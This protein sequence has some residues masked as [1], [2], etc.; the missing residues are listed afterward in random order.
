MEVGNDYCN[1]YAHTKVSLTIENDQNGQWHQPIP[2]STTLVSSLQD[3]A[4]PDRIP[5]NAT[6]ASTHRRD[7]PIVGHGRS[8]A[9]GARGDGGGKRA[10]AQ[11]APA[12]SRSGISESVS[13]SAAAAPASTVD[14]ISH[15]N[16][17]RPGS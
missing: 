14:G 8:L 13:A 1:D 11:T 7:I 2:V 12:E 9:T 4:P 10:G 15:L 6:A 16:Y 17:G 5:A 3:T